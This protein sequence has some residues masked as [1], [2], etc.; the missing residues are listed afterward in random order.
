MATAGYDYVLSGDS[1][2]D[3][4]HITYS[5]PADGI[6]WDHGI[7][8]LNATFDAK[9]GAGVWERI[10]ARALAT[11]QSVANIDISQ[12]ADGNEDFDSLGRAQGDPRFGDIR[13]GG[14]AYNV[15]TTILAQTFFP[16]PNGSTAAGD[17]EANT[18]INFNIGSEYDLYSVALHEMG[19]ALG[20]DHALNP[21]NV[22]YAHYQGVRTGL[23][24]GDIAGIQAIYGPRTPDSYQAQGL[25]LSFSSSIDLSAGLARNPN[26]EITGVSLPRIGSSEYYSFV[27]PAN[28]SQSLQITA[29]AAN[30]SMLSPKLSLYDGSGNLVARASN[31]S[32]WS[33]NI[34]VTASN[35]VPGQ[36][37]YVVASG[38]TGDYFDVG[39]YQLRVSL[40]GSIPSN[41]V[42]LTSPNNQG[43]TFPTP[44]VQPLAIRTAAAP[45]RYEPNNSF[46]Q[47][48]SL[49]SVSQ[50][51]LDHLSLDSATDRDYF[52][53]KPARPGAYRIVA[54]GASISIF[55]ARGR[56]IAGGHN[57]LTINVPKRIT[58]YVVLVNSSSHSIIPDYTLSIA[59]AHPAKF[60]TRHAARR[61][62]IPKKVAKPHPKPSIHVVKP[63]KHAV[64]A[65]P[66]INIRRAV[67]HGNLIRQAHPKFG[68]S[69]L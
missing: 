46:S 64:R 69:F 9:F 44:T 61:V 19:H 4:S 35:V 7:N 56:L 51:D 42:V 6:F 37:Y 55:D 2:A 63:V 28:A 54:S 13:L 47:A 41:P 33:D 43:S 40:P 21:S 29:V 65:I 16:P 5:I 24:D 57:Q 23:S 26:V 15:S 20:L 8:N 39:G 3:P 12:V 31:P 36:R 34:T 22:M 53:F 50:I 30:I 27:V 67:V 62:T 68:L 52:R 11:W 48:A 45:D 1:W 49:G 25:G 14:Y 58:N 59:P 10:F 66:A 60:Q 32:A 38:A 18:S 17:F